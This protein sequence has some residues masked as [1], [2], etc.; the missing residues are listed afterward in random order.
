LIGVIVGDAAEAAAEL[1]AFTDAS[2]P[3]E[4][5]DNI[6]AIDMHNVI[7]LLFIIRRINNYLFSALA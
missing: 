7:S 4:I 6:T 5:S 3:L 2:G 1:T